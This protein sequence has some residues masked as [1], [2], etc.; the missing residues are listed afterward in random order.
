MELA[1]FVG[2]ETGDFNETNGTVGTVSVVSTPVYS[3]NYAYRANPATTTTGYLT[4]EGVKTT[5]GDDS[6]TTGT[7]LYIAFRFRY[8]VKPA[9]G[10][11]PIC[12]NGDLSAEVR[13]DSAGKLSFWGNTTQFG[14][15]GATVLSANTWYLIAVKFVS[16]AW[17]VKIN[18]VSEISGSDAFTSTFT[19]LNLGKAIDRSGQT[20][21][22][23]YDDVGY[24]KSEYPPEITGIVILP[25]N[26]AGTY[27]T[28]T[29]GGSDSGSNWN[30]VD[31]LITY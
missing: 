31:E 19:R 28:W 23:F 26:A 1:N 11:E 16:G 14:S 29:R 21:D 25:A 24:A 15:T 20:V 17:E 30:Q 18:G 27:Q 6:D 9:S 8:A 5:D 3:G 10:S 13:I 12:R 7:T 2:F 4:I 22:F